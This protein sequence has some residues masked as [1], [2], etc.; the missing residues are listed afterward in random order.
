MDTKEQ[1]IAKTQE[2]DVA[3]AKLA[4]TAWG[5]GPEWEKDVPDDWHTKWICSTQAVKKA[6]LKKQ[7]KQQ[8]EA[9]IKVAHVLEVLTREKAHFGLRLDLL[10]AL[11]ILGATDGDCK[12]A[13]WKQSEEYDDKAT[14]LVVWTCETG[15]CDPPHAVAARTSALFSS[16][17]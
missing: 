12:A 10:D 2:K 5:V 6:V 3:L 11:E 7:H 14:P 9:R 4:A 13:G 15:R 17:P 8:R 16:H 1:Q